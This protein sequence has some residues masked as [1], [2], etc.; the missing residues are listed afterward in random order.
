MKHVLPLLLAAFVSYSSLAQTKD[1]VMIGAGYSDHVWY[2]LETGEVARSAKDRWDFAF[3]VSGFGS[4]ILLNHLN[5]NKLYVYPNGDTASW[6]TL[7]TNGIS[8]WSQLY[9]SDTSWNY[10]AFN[11]NT[12]RDNDFDLGWGVYNMITHQVVGDSLFVLQ[13][14]NAF[15]K[16]WIKGLAGGVYTVKLANLDGSQEVDVAIN[17]ADYGQRNFVYYSV[18]ANEIRNL[19][20]LNDA[21]DLKFTQYTTII[22]SFGGYPASGV[23]QNG[24]VTTA[25]VSEV[26]DPLNFDDHERQEFSTEIN[27]IGHDW[28]SF[29]FA[30]N[31]WSIDD[32]TV[33]FVR[34][35]NGAL[36]RLVFTDFGGSATGKYV[37][38]KELIEEASELPQGVEAPSKA[39]LQI[40]PNP[41]NQGW[42]NLLYASNAPVQLTIH[43]LQGRVVYSAQQGA[44]VL[45]QIQLSTQ[46]WSAGMYIV[47]MESSGAT[48]TQKLIIN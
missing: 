23:L 28:K 36:W 14:G 45:G 21:W 29:D 20:P 19:E 25:Q 35:R 33:Y 17:K 46:A 44:A 38:Q 13:Q 5:D 31:Q 43:D 41:S 30:T 27:T 7:D 48:Q 2:S 22:P 47:R 40:Y 32:S 18:S 39:S 34:A 37:F 3:S 8:T 12:D 26:G 11:A 6:T 16:I 9:N 10:G 4:S 1:S 15:K 24:N 42:A